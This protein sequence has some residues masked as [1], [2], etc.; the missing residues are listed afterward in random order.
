MQEKRKIL[1]IVHFWERKINPQNGKDQART[2]VSPPKDQNLKI[3]SISPKFDTFCMNYF[4]LSKI[5][6]T[7]AG[8]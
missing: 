3:L 8:K 5:S 1:K 4:V 6:R 7:F 2:N